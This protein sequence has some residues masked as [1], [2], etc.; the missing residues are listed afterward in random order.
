MSLIS[1]FNIKQ[2]FSK[3]K[4]EEE[5]FSF[6]FFLTRLIA[7]VMK[8]LELKQEKTKVGMGYQPL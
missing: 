3:I 6:F 4:L 1:L 5:T 7:I 2:L 8:K